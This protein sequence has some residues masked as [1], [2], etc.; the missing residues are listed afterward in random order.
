M[1]RFFAIVVLC[2]AVVAGAKDAL[3][4][5]WEFRKDGETAWRK[6]EV[7]HDW[8]IEEAPIR[9]ACP[10]Q[11]NLQFA[12]KGRYRCRLDGFAPP[13]GGR[14]Y[15]DFDGVM[16]RS[17]IFL[18]GER[19]GGTPFGYTSEVIDITD[20][21]K[22]E[23]NILEVTAENVPHSSRWYPGSGIFREVKVRVV[24]RNH[25]KPRT[26]F[27]RTV[28]ANEKSAT[29]AV[30][31]EWAGGA[32][33]Y[34]S[35]VAN[36]RLWSPETPHLYELELFGE[37]FRYGIRKAEFILRA[38]DAKGNFC[39]TAKLPVELKVTGGWRIV[40]VGNGDAS[41]H[42]PSLGVSRVN[43]FNGLALVVVD[44]RGNGSIHGGMQ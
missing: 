1:K 9:D 31:F 43:L 21:L 22:P 39:P 18:N 7:P 15:L 2:F 24:P 30:S 32:S 11:G 27:I 19:V 10:H 40:A 6:V 38:V 13:P 23:G 5:D 26:L 8:A 4:S 3:L 16:C 29:V 36:P 33:N 12:G 37:K 28:D 41:D 44:K 42:S 35:T 17:E 25:V 14:T 34:A 20:R